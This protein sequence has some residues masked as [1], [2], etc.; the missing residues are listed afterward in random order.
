MGKNSGSILSANIPDKAVADL[1]MNKGIDAKT[2]SRNIYCVFHLK[3]KK[4]SNCP[5]NQRV[6]V[7]DNFHHP[8]LLI[9]SINIERCNS[10]LPET[11]NSEES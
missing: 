9:V 10:P 8:A 4:A 1:Q 7:I 3:T 6:K 5:F 2:S 11:K